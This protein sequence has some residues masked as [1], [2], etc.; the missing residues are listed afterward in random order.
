MTL[1]NNDLAKIHIARKDLAM[2]DDSY[3]ALLQRVTGKESASAL[4]IAERVKV[5]A[6]FTRLGWKP[7][8]KS[9]P[10][11]HKPTNP[12]DWRL[13]RLNLIRHL[14]Q[15]LHEKGQ[16]RNADDDAL[17]AFCGQHMEAERLEWATSPELNKCVEALKSW[18]RR[19]KQ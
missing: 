2:T 19:T 17:Q 13:P 7:K 4:S 16:V 10:N 18:Q 14:W 8:P 1:R 5:M 15:W 11:P 12:D 9:K 3:R 6:E